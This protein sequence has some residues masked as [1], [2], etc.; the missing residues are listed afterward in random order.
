[1][2]NWVNNKFA[3]EGDPHL[4]QDFINEATDR[5]K[6]DEFSFHNLYPMPDELNITCGSNLTD[7]EK[8]QQKTNLQKYGCEDWYSWRNKHWGTKWDCVDP[9]YLSM[10]R[11]GVK[12]SSWRFNTAW[13]IPRGLIRY[14]TKKFPE[15]LFD[16]ESKCES[17]WKEHLR[18]IDER[19]IYSEYIEST[20]EDQY[21]EDA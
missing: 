4:V 7:K 13:D 10:E 21:E 14:L 9:T 2:P 11:D 17:G 8:E 20:Y 19:I 3:V 18:M 15:L 1:M 16:I 12:H 6:T 5:G